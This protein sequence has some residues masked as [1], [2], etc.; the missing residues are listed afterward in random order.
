MKL[1]RLISRLDVKGGRLV[2]GVHLEGLR[3][4]GDPEKFSEYYYNEGADELFFQDTE[5]S[6]YQRNNLLDIVKKTAKNIFIPLIVGG[7][8]RK[9]EDIKKLLKAGADRV[10]INTHAISN[11]AFINE[12]ARVFGSSTIVISIEV[13]KQ[14]NKKYYA[15]TDN[16]REET[17]KDAVE[18]AQEAV[19]RGA[20]E[21]LITSIDKDGTGEGF[22]NNLINIIKQKVSVPVVAHGGAGKLEHLRSVFVDT[23]VDAICL[24]SMLH[25]G[26]LKSDLKNLLVQ[27]Y[28]GNTD[29]I[30]KKEEYKSFTSCSIAQIKKYLKEQNIPVRSVV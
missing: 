27:N 10:A 18:W 29:F 6:L 23:Q 28:E 30:H 21:I 14:K 17:N 25:Y 5:A 13:I 15:F 9:I 8:I 16:G 3:V 4:I 2:K 19:Q 20:G 11:P 1:K 24:A 7:G 26:V 12:A 22:D